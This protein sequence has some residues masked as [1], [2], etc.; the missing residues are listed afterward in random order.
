[1]LRPPPDHVLSEIEFVALRLF[2]D[3]STTATER[4]A[5]GHA[6]FGTWTTPAGGVVVTTGCTDWACGL[7]GGDVDVETVTHNILRRLGSAR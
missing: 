7:G 3:S 5:Y 6:V 4:I 1:M 2:G